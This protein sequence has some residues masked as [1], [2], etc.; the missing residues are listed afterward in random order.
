M[1]TDY[2]QEA[3]ARS[4]QSASNSRVFLLLALYCLISYLPWTIIQSNYPRLAQMK[5]QPAYD[6]PHDRSY[7]CSNATSLPTTYNTDD[8]LHYCL[9]REEG[10]RFDGDLGKGSEESV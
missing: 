9:G 1:T 4:D 7:A 2:D 10:F 5:L 3:Q 6:D 8:T